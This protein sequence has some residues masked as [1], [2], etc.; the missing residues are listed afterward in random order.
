MDGTLAALRQGVSDYIL[1]PINA[2]ALRNSVCRIV[3]RRR[4]EHE[5]KTEQAFAKQI[6]DTAEAVILVLDLR[7]RVVRF[8]PFFTKITG[9]QPAELVGQDWFDHCIQSADQDWLR[10][11]FFRTAENMST[12]GVVNMVLTRDGRTRQ[13]RWSNTTL[14][15]ESDQVISVLS[16]GVDVSDLLAAQ[17]SALRSQRLAAIGQT[18]AALAHESRNALQRIQAGVEMLGLEIEGNPQAQNELGTIQRAARDLNELLEEV[19]S[20]AGP[21]QLNMEDGNLTDAWRRA[22]DNLAKTR[23]GRKIVLIESKGHVDTNVQF[24]ALRMEM[25]FRNLFENSYA[26]C[27]DPVE[28]EINCRQ[29]DGSWIEIRVA[30]NGPGLNKEQCER[31]FEPFYTTK[32]A[33]TGLGMSIV[34]RIMQAHGGEIDVEQTTCHPTGAVFI[35]RFPRNN[36]G[37]L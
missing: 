13:I 8:N 10:E 37:V 30:D 11:V 32:S 25:V 23:Q 6:L 2:D 5:L 27:E 31:L 22:W 28:I 35:L 21:I 36:Q 14:R 19:R 16:V 20:F 34:R 18:M 3:E 24:D 15:D 7:G 26:A 9:W 29:V 4:I 33:G 1:K 12:S 17:E